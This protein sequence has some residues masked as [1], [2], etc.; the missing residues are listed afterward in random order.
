MLKYAQHQGKSVPPPM[1]GLVRV[2]CDR[3][4]V[5]ISQRRLDRRR[6]PLPVRMCGTSSGG[7]GQ[8]QSSHPGLRAHGD[9]RCSQFTKQSRNRS[10]T[11]G[12]GSGGPLRPWSIRC[13]TAPARVCGGARVCRRGSW[14]QSFDQSPRLN[15]KC[16]CDERNGPH[17]TKNQIPTRA[18]FPMLQ[19]LCFLSPKS[20]NGILRRRSEAAEIFANIQV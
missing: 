16:R 9:S 6:L 19:H 11:R 10:R 2:V 4:P 7:G 20:L 8:P 14:P 18:S 15:S 12:S 17:E 1:T 3:R 13:P 5:F